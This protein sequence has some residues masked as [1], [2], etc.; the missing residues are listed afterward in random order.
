MRLFGL[1]IRRARARRKA[2]P[3]VMN[4]VADNRGGW[5]PFRVREPFAGAWQRD[6]EW[7]S[8]TV[9][10]HWAV[11]A[12]ITLIANDIGKL[13][14]KLVEQDSDGIWSETSSPSFSPVLRRPNRYQNH[15]QFKEW[16]TTSKL[17]RGNTYVL[18]R[19][20]GRGVV[21]AEYVLDPNR[22]TVMVA[23]DGS[24]FYKLQADNLTGLAE[25]AK[26]VPAKE[27]IHDRINCLFHPLIGVSPIYACGL[28]ANMGLQITRNS[29]RF[30][31]NNSNPG[32][33]LTAPKTIEQATAD[34]IKEH[35]DR[36]YTGENAGKVAVLGDGL[37]FEPMRMTNEDSQLIEQLKFT[38]E[39]VC[40]AFH[41][42]PFMVGIGNMPTHNNAE[43]LNQIYYSQCLQSHIEQYELCQD[44]GMGIGVANKLTE[45]KVL[46]VELDL[47]G[48]LR[49]D[50]ATQMSVIKEGV[51]AGVL[52][53]NEGRRK[54]DLKP[55]KGGDT[56]YLQQQNYSL[57]ALDERDKAG[58]PPNSAGDRRQTPPPAPPAPPAG[59]GEDENEEEEEAAAEER[60]ADALAAAIRL[61]ARSMSTGAVA[62]RSGLIKRLLAEQ[63]P[64]AAP[65]AAQP[66]VIHLTLVQPGGNNPI[67]KKIA[68]TTA[69][70]EPRVA[71]ITEE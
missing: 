29:S 31:Q 1:Y 24:V 8:D 7:D 25:E 10:A 20:D 38:A 6:I 41:V 37:K 44:E 64:K 69:R 45:G 16:W 61:R 12:C 39:M 3:P 33:V 2:A 30:F 58:P 36:E 23:P 47:D 46:G 13:R 42:P 53:P 62:S 71:T 28:A 48:L 49:M 40:G 55:V 43:L 56:P 68:Y 59:G 11:Y 5:W 34:R 65:T 27:I 63:Q 22:V 66:P 54:L 50:S 4:T 32:G 70:G 67:T 9:T 19:R 26:V 51:G 57:A 21:D 17:M 15:I 18:L 35:W 60:A 52:K 14:Q